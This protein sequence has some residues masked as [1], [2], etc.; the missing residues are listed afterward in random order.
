MV[1]HNI[2]KYPPLPIHTTNIID[3]FPGRIKNPLSSSS[4]DPEIKEKDNKENEK[5]RINNCI[6][7]KL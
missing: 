4:A 6:I 3:V 7:K 2:Y 1:Y 5:S